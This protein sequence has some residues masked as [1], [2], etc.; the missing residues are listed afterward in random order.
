MS[1]SSMI[2]YGNRMRFGILIFVALILA[3]IWFYKNLN[4]SNKPFPASEILM[5]RYTKEEISKKQY[6]DMKKDLL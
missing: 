3:I 5:Q 2:N 1:D 4:V 6:H